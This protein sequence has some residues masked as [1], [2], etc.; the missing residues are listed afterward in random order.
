MPNADLAYVD[1]AH[2]TFWEATDDWIQ[3]V[4]EWLARTDA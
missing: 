4:T 2:M 1:G 3:I